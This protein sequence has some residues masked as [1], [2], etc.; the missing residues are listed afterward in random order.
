[1]RN[2]EHLG[3]VTAFVTTA[4]LGSFTAASER[5]GLTKSAVGKSVSRLENR[6]GLKLFLRATR[7]LSL[8]PEG[9]RFLQSCQN[10][11]DILQQAEA[12]LTSHIARPAGRLR[13]DLP[14]AFGRQRILPLLLTIIRRYPELTLTVTFSERFVD[15]IE[16][17]IDLV[18]RIGELAD[19]S[20]LVARRLTTQKLVICAAADYL[21]QYGEPVTPQ[22]LNRHHCI[23]GFRR[24]QPLS[25]LLKHP[26][27]EISRYTP[28]A[29]HEFAD[30]DGMLSAVLAGCGISQ[31]PLWLVGRHLKSGELKEVLNGYSGGEIPVS[32]LWP[33]NR[34]LLPKIRYVADELLQAAAD[35]LLD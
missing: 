24:H 10:A 17:G 8:T 9:E 11:L 22:E 21:A 6:L 19:S 28:P 29:T 25:W 27:G 15:P 18:I 14:A 23:T 1:M 26:D 34:Q 20:G 30:G 3:G 35:G 31:L 2:T 13:V 7:R 4:Q 5:L 33:K 32:I 12:E 16:E